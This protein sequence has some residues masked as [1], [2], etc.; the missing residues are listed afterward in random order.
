[1]PTERLSFQSTYIPRLEMSGSASYS[2]SNNVAANLYDSINEWTASTTSQVR[3][4][5]VSGPANAKEIFV[6]ANWSAIY[7]LTQKL[8]LLDSIRYDQWQNPGYNT[9]TTTSLFATAAPVGSGDVGILL[10]IAQFAPLVASGPTVPTFASIC[11]STATRHR[12]LTCPQHEH[13]Y[14]YR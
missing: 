12:D 10:P 3:D 9:Q 1:M 6:H 4:S 5:I 2:S 8:R 7:S 11:P 13:Q 14:H